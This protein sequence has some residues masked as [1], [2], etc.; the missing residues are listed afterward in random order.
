MDRFRD[1]LP[2]GAWRNIYT[3]KMHKDDIFKKY[4][5]FPSVNF[6][7]Q[8]QQID[9]DT[10]LL[11]TEADLKSL[12]LPLGPFRKLSFA[13]QERKNALTNPGGI[14]DSHL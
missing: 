4:L 6:R 11:L 12:G 2:F 5:I 9:L 10:L 8:K 13:I 14:R 3:C 1:F 7:F